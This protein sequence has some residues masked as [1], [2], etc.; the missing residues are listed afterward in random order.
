MVAAAVTGVAAIVLPAVVAASGLAVALLCLGALAAL[1]ALSG[2]VATSV[3]STRSARARRD[4]HTLTRV[5]GHATGAA[6]A[7]TSLPAMAFAAAFAATAFAYS[8]S[9]ITELPAAVGATLFCVAVTASVAAGPRVTPVVRILGLAGVA[10]T[11]I[12][13]LTGS[14]DKPPTEI[15]WWHPE[16]GDLTRALALVMPALA[17]ALLPLGRHQTT[18]H[19]WRASARAQTA[20]VIAAATI[21]GV[22]AL[23]AGLR[24]G[25]LMLAKGPAAFWEY[26]RSGFLLHIGLW[27]TLFS[28]AHAAISYCADALHAL[29]LDRVAPRLFARTEGALDGRRIALVA[30]LPLTLALAL[31]ANMHSAGVAASV[32]SLAVVAALCLAVA[33][34]E[35]SAATAWRPERRVSAVVACAASVFALYIGSVIQSLILIPALLL[36]AGIHTLAQRGRQE[37]SGSGADELWLSLAHSALRRVAHRG[38][39]SSDRHP[40]IVA[41]VG[42]PDDNEK[43][44]EVAGLLAEG[45]GIATV[46]YLVEGALRTT[47]DQRG[48]MRSA[49][50]QTVHKRY[51]GLLARVE[52]VPQVWSG[53]GQVAQSY[54][55]GGFEASTALVGWPR[56]GRDP[57]AFLGA[58]RDLSALGRRVIAVHEHRDRGFGERRDI[59]VWWTDNVLGATMLDI[60][61]QLA[62]GQRWEGCAITVLSYVSDEGEGLRRR[63]AIRS[64]T[65]HYGSEVQIRDVLAMPDRSE[66]RAMRERC[67]DADLIIARLELSDDESGDEAFYTRKMHQLNRLPSVLY[68]V[69]PRHAASVDA[70]TGSSVANP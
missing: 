8:W 17:A 34:N 16:R 30:V 54:G 35:W 22:C 50:E 40:N 42:D 6:L 38:L 66:A 49:L 46:V 36:I 28:A 62:S 9:L 55:V 47:G 11:L 51:P 33:I 70:A 58:I 19:T 20:A 24:L 4:A 3:L 10:L 32:M 29:A 5:F 68:V 25:D 45:R 39:Q 27:L 53:I 15:R 56:T 43:T 1:L 63:A 12:L 41:F 13:I 65:Q 26:T 21:L 31:P 52:V 57:A 61:T 37:S 69:A 67:K 7:W 14:S 2:T 59:Y 44:I 18:A 48:A 60:A 64:A 23:W